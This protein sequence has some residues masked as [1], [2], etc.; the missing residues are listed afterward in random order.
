MMTVLPLISTE[1]QKLGTMVVLEDISGEKRVRA[2]MARYMDP[3]IADQLLSTGAEIL[4]GKSV[5]AGT[6]PFTG[7]ARRVPPIEPLKPASPKA[8]TPPS[9]ATS[10]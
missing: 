6:K 5:P 2:T 9:A 4:G 8:K 10:Q 7:L 3:S 1:A